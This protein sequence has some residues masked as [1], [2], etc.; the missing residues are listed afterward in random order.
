MRTVLESQSS[1]S[2]QMGL[3]EAPPALS[4]HRCPLEST[5]A[6]YASRQTCEYLLLFHRQQEGLREWSVR[7]RF[8]DEQSDRPRAQSLDPTPWKRRSRPDDLTKGCHPPRGEN[9]GT[10]HCVYL[11]ASR[12]YVPR[13]KEGGAPYPFFWP[14]TL[15]VR[16]EQSMRPL[17]E[18]LK[19]GHPEPALAWAARVP[20]GWRCSRARHRHWASYDAEAAALRAPLTSVPKALR[21][22]C[23]HL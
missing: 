18:F 7:I 5:P 22:R 16:V 11:S 2:F 6:G 1:Q 20:R 17:G 21:P 15:R 9:D 10:L 4:A 8:V 14:S 3:T 23:Q 12:R 19:T 13:V